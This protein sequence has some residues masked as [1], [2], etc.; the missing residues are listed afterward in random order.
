MFQQSNDVKGDI[1]DVDSY[2]VE[3]FGPE[4]GKEKTRRKG[5]RKKDTKAILMFGSDQTNRA[6]VEKA[7][8]ESHHLKT[9]SGFNRKRPKQAPPPPPARLGTGCASMLGYSSDF[10]MGAQNF[11]N[12]GKSIVTLILQ[13]FYMAVRPI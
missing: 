5:R 3:E 4:G 12:S 8:K 9:P 11:F 10:S 6:N 2:G 1:F 7:V 13:I